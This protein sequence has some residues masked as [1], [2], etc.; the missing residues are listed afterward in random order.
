MTN[1]ASQEM[2][3]IERFKALKPLWDLFIEK[4]D[5]ETAI[6]G[7]CYLDNYL[8]KIIKKSFIEDEKVNS[9]FKNDHILQSFNA[10]INIAYFSG[11]IM[12][13]IYHDLKIICEIRN[14][15][16]HDM[17]T[18]L[19]FDSN[20]I[21]QKIEKLKLPPNDI[22]IFSQPKLKFRIVVVIIILTL[23]FTDEI[24]SRKPNQHLVDIL[25]S[26][27]EIASYQ[28]QVETLVSKIKKIRK[29]QVKS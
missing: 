26:D 22:Q 15:F 8:E 12:K 25:T 7:V 11:L 20:N 13:D 29:N 4:S 10:K 16:A 17:M 5:R 6:V 27:Q 14:K 3:P 23:I 18:E 24:L 28:E 21:L 19:D 2:N 1:E 9:I